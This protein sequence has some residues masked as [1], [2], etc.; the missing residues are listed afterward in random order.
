VGTA[1]GADVG[2]LDGTAFERVRTSACR[3]SAPYPLPP[4]TLS[5]AVAID[6]EGAVHLK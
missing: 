4:T 6:D 3:L 2:A 5:V 1:V